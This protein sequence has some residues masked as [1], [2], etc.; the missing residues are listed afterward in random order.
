[1]SGYDLSETARVQ[2]FLDGYAALCRAHGF[3]VRGIAL[4]VEPLGT[5]GGVHV[6]RNPDRSLT[7]KE[8]LR[9]PDPAPYRIISAVA[10]Q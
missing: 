9:R 4:R 5:F 3:A 8:H 7:L 10:K 1:M 2:A 6:E